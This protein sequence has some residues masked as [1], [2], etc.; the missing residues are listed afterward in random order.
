MFHATRFLGVFGACAL[1]ALSA[2]A[3]TPS[4]ASLA[5]AADALVN[6]ADNLARDATDEAASNQY[7]VRWGG[8]AHQLA[9]AAQQFRSAVAAP[10]ARRADIDA[11]F[12]RLSQAYDATR[13]AVSQS[14]LLQPRRDLQHVTAAYEDVERQLGRAAHTPA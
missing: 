14:V 3:A 13:E 7:E 6:Y 8:D 5:D 12:T 10:D 9:A 11:A 2:C 4:R 1:M